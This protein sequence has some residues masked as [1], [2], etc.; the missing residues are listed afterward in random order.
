MKRIARVLEG[1]GVT[2]AAVRLVLT[3]ARSKEGLCPVK[4]G[5]AIAES[6]LT[7]V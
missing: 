1:F 7:L 5:N 4:T 3:T 2:T 6:K